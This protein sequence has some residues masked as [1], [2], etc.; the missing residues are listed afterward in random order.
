[1][2]LFSQGPKGLG[3]GPTPS[4]VYTLSS[5]VIGLRVWNGNDW[6]GQ[7]NLDNAPW[8][9]T[10]TLSPCART[11]FN[12]SR[13]GLSTNYYT[14]RLDS[15]LEVADSY[16]IVYS[17]CIIKTCN[18]YYLTIFNPCPPGLTIWIEQHVAGNCV[19]FLCCVFIV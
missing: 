16:D 7:P 2:A 12:Y 3:S 8:P 15:R 10:S 11:S 19:V 1:M 4:L 9:L 6:C 17:G 18:L 5:E 13:T 14:C